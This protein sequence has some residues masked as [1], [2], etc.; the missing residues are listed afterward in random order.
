LT[1]K[2]E[3]AEKSYGAAYYVANR[4]RILARVAARAATHREQIAVYK[5]AYYAAHREQI[6][7]DSRAY[8][9]A[10]PGIRKGTKAAYR[11]AHQEERR[12]SDAAWY[13]AHREEAGE[14]VRAWCAT[15]PERSRASHAAWK[16]A[17]PATVADHNLAR[18]GR[19]LGA[20]GVATVAEI[21]ARWTYHGDK[22]WIC[23]GI[24]TATDHVKP[25]AKGGS[26]WPANLRPVCLTCN[27]SKHAKWPYPVAA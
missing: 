9:A 19:K 26:N 27:S 24:A 11:K 2:T 25:L 10:H 15:N 18:R 5:R 22:C 3:G 1:G 14:R 23:G 20:E 12:A 16:K 17:N 6:A 13:V 21:A 4:E 7:I 8:Y